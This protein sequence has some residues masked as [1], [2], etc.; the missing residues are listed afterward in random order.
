MLLSFLFKEAGGAAKHPP[1]SVKQTN[2]KGFAAGGKRFICLGMAL[3]LTGLFV[4]LP[5][6]HAAENSAAAA[7]TAWLEERISRASEG[8]SALMSEPGELLHA[9]R[10]HP[11]SSDDWLV[12][13]L[14]VSGSREYYT[15]YQQR[16]KEH[17]EERYAADGLLD[18]VKAT[19][20]HRTAIVYRTLGGDPENC[21]KKPDG[22]P[23][24]LIADGTYDYV[25]RELGL[26]GMNGLVWALLTL[27]F[28]Q[29]EIPEDARYS[30]QD[31]IDEIC[32]L[33]EP[34]GGFGLNPGGCDVDI[35]A[36]VIQALAPYK[37]D[38]GQVIEDALNW[39]ASVETDTCGF[40]NYHQEN[41]E[42]VSQVILAL[43]SLGIDPEED[44]RFVR[45][46]LTPLANLERFSFPDGTYGHSLEDIKGDGIAT[47]QALQALVSV[48]NLRQ[49]GKYVF[50]SGT[51]FPL[52]DKKTGISPVWVII[53][54]A[55]IV[56]ICVVLVVKK[57]GKAAKKV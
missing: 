20:Y 6:V 57:T 16:I 4:R 38:C 56:L 23:V 29:T 2:R 21:G 5:A 25:G 37:A 41:A 8:L 9:E 7:D 50:A 31:I 42:S 26:Q 11:G 19:D 53:P 17:V 46:N 40:I 43:C 47:A 15:D 27:D 14:A 3:V 18:E 32:S 12:Y 1:A 54:V 33:Q 51:E 24:D 55:A 28:F 22:S 10:M 30:R 13:S 52:N 35:T 34:E 36:M 49:G 48:R 44:P 39:L 45:G